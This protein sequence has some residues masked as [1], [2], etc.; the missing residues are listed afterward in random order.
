MVLEYAPLT[1]NSSLASRLSRSDAVSMRG[2][3]H[4]LAASA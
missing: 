3:A 1:A 2:I 4:D